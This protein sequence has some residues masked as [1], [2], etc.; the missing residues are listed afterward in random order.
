MQITAL[1]LIEKQPATETFAPRMTI[2]QDTI[3]LL[4]SI[5]KNGYDEE[6]IRIKEEF[7][8]VD[9]KVLDEENKHIC[10]R[11]IQLNP[12]RGF[13]KLLRL[14]KRFPFDH[15]DVVN[16]Y[17]QRLA[18]CGVTCETGWGQL[19]PGIFPIDLDCIE[20]ITSDP[21]YYKLSHSLLLEGTENNLPWY[22]YY[23]QLKLYII[24]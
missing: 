1:N 2:C 11:G 17:K 3:I 13:S 4:G 16:I 20:N 15:D 24:T 5:I 10:F 21:R 7:N 19:Q 8:P 9:I 23:A 18:L 12:S 22:S 6:R 14:L